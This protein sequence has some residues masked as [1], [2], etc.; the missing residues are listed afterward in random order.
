MFGH[1]L[2]RLLPVK[3]QNTPAYNKQAKGREQLLECRNESSQN[4]TLYHSKGRVDAKCRNV[5]RSLLIAEE[6]DC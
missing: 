5:L 2:S 3:P 1:T 4:S 6:L